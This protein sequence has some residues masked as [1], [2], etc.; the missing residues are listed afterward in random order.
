MLILH[1]DASWHGLSMKAAKDFSQNETIYKI[2][3]Y[4]LSDQPSYRTIQ[5]DRDKHIDNSN[6][7]AYL[8]HSCR[9]NIIVDVTRMEL[10]ALHDINAGELLTYFYPSTEWEMAR[11]FYCRCGSLKCLGYIAGAKTVARG[12]LHQ[13]FINTHIHQLVD[14]YDAK[15]RSQY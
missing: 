10:T 2:R 14:K 6:V 7:L 5:I 11:P 9:P 8:N 3:D 4:Q 12:I 15:I 13:Y 1:H